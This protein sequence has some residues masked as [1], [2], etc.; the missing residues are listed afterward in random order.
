MPPSKPMT[1]KEFLCRLDAKL[2]ERMKPELDRIAREA[3]DEYPKSDLLA[4]CDDAE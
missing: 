3:W 1:S 2:R 4:E